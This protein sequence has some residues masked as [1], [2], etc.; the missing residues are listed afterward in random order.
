MD[1]YLVPAGFGE[2]EFTEKKLEDEVCDHSK[3]KDYKI[4]Y[5]LSLRKVAQI[6]GQRC[7]HEIK[8][9]DL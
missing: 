8:A 7:E 6:G 4:V 9:K 1:E 5:A 3:C 2:D